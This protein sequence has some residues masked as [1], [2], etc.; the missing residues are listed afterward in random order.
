MAA[1]PIAAGPRQNVRDRGR[2]RP[3]DRRFPACERIHRLS[4]DYRERRN[5]RLHRLH[6][7]FVLDRGGTLGALSGIT[8][9]SIVAL[10]KMP[11]RICVTCGICGFLICVIGGSPAVS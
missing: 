1:E 11:K 3:S 4:A 5:H 6:R 7:L 10:T 9:T 2:S 8:L